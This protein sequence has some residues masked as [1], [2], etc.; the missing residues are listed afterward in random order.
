[1]DRMTAAPWGK[2]TK[3]YKTRVNKR[4]DR[5]IIRGRNKGKG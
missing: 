4:T 2:P 1:G 5:L 3:G